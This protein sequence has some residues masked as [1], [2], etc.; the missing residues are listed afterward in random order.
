[1]MAISSVNLLKN[2]ISIDQA[3]VLA[4]ILREHPTLKSLCGN[5]SDET[6]LGMSGKMRGAGDAIMLAAEIIDNGALYYLD[7][8]KND[9]RATGCKA[10]AEALKGNQVMR[11]LNVADNRLVLKADVEDLSDVD[12]SG[13]ATLADVISNMGALTSLNVADNEFK[14][15]GAKYITDAIKVSNCVLQSFWHHFYVHMTTGSTAV[16]C[17]YPQNTA[18]S[19]FDISN[20]S[21]LAAGTE[22]LAE[23][24]EGNQIMTELNISANG[25]GKSGAIAL[26]GIIPGM[27]ALNSLNL[28][29]NGSQDG[30]GFAES[31]AYCLKKNT[32]LKT[33]N[34]S[35]NN[36]SFTDDLFSSLCAVSKVL[37]GGNNFSGIENPC[38]KVLCKRKV[39]EVQSI[40][41]VDL[42]S[43]KLTGQWFAVFC[44]VYHTLMY[45]FCIQDLFLGLPCAT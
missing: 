43:Q 35:D 27:V 41:K 10:L 13:V 11:E 45:V 20:N 36:I 15:E 30:S 2:Y 7:I 44:R 39:L 29:Q 33:V 19:N 9:I 31:F 40:G 1:M 12:M 8:S 18:L 17:C 14:A 21:L 34:I 6:E 24:L 4:S 16:V 25:I 3:E 38:L 42:H 32:S 26:A 22:A 5:K 37:A 28:S 23:G